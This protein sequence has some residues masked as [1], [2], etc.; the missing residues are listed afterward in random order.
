MNEAQVG[1]PLKSSI[2]SKPGSR[3]SKRFRLENMTS[4]PKFESSTKKLDMTVVEELISD[5]GK[6]AD[7]DEE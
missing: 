1:T 4:P 3:E 5:E 7:T 2:D 6:Y